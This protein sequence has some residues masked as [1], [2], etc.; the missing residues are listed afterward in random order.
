MRILIKGEMLT[1][2]Q[3]FC[4]FRNNEIKHFFEMGRVVLHFKANRER[5]AVSKFLSQGTYFRNIVLC[6]GG[7]NTPACSRHGGHGSV[8]GKTH[9]LDATTHC[10]LHV[11]SHGSDRVTASEGMGVKIVLHHKFD[12]VLSFLPRRYAPALAL[13]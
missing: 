1:E 10:R 8:I 12:K 9:V 11:F 2:D 6:I 13:R 4:P 5:N 7:R 3:I